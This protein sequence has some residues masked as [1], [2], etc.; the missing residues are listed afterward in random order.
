MRQAGLFGLSEHL[1]RL[2][3]DGDPLEVLA[4]TVDFEDF[5]PWLVEG[6]GF[7]DGSKG[8]RPP[9]EPVSM[10][11]VLLLQAQHNR[12]D[13]RMKFMP[14]GICCAIACQP[15]HP[16]PTVVDA[17]LASGS[18]RAPAGRP[19]PADRDGHAEAGDD[20][21]KRRVHSVSRLAVAEE[22]IHPRLADCRHSPVGQRTA[23]IAARRTR[24][25]RRSACSQAA[26][27][28]PSQRKNRCRGTSP[29]RPRRN[30]PSAPPSSTVEHVFAH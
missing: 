14:V 21:A 6:L 9:F 11:K 7:G 8:G 18:R 5:R 27:I 16:R 25:G 24:R 20:V 23:L 1:D 3:K 2:S 12:S 29:G 30:P 26:S 28:G 13:A 19:Q 22:G 10:F 17:V 15:A 4:A